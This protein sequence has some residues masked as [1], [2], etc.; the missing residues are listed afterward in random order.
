MAEEKGEIP[1]RG[2]LIWKYSTGNQILSSPVFHNDEV[3]LGSDDGYL[4]CLNSS[5]GELNWRYKTNGPI[6]S[7]ALINGDLAY[8]GSQDKNFYCTGV[9][10]L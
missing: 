8:F 10:K 5:T 7:T 2:E 3:I 6:R 4:Y 9:Y 1:K